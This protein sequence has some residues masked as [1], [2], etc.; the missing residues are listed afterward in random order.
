M[1]A[2]YFLSADNL[3]DFMEFCRKPSILEADDL[4]GACYRKAMTPPKLWTLLF[5]QKCS[6]FHSSVCTSGGS[7]QR[8]EIRVPVPGPPLVNLCGPVRTI[9]RDFP[10]TSYGTG[11]GPGGRKH[12]KKCLQPVPVRRLH[13]PPMGLPKYCQTTT[14]GIKSTN[15]NLSKQLSAAHLSD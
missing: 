14:Q 12:L 8:R 11:P 5:P 4:L 10:Q 6:F 9:L 3:G 7:M 15:Q 13:L 1:H 2:P